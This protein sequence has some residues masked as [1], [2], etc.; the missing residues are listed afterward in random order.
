[1]ENQTNEFYAGLTIGPIMDV[2]RHS[3]KTKEQW[4]GSYFFSWYMEKVMHLLAK[5]LGKDI[6]LTPH[7]PDANDGQ[8]KSYG[9]KF[10]DRFVLKTNCPHD[11]LFNHIQT[12]CL[13]TQQF[14]ANMIHTIV[15]NK[16][17]SQKLMDE[18]QINETLKHYLQIRFFCL[19]SNAFYSHAHAENKDLPVAIAYNILDSLES[20]TIVK[21]GK[22]DHTCDVCK[23]LPACANHKD[24]H[25]SSPENLCPMCYIKR[26]AGNN[27]KLSDDEIRDQE[28]D[29][30]NRVP[31]ESGKPI[32]PSLSEISIHELSHTH[33]DVIKDC[34]NEDDDIDLEKLRVKLPKKF[35]KYH[36]YFAIVQA[37][38]DNLGKLA[39]DKDMNPQT[40]SK[41]LFDF[42]EQTEGIIN[43]YGG[44]PVFLGGDDI[45]AYMPV[46]YQ[47]M[48]VIDFI[49]DTSKK[50]AEIVDQGKN[51]TTISFG[52]NIV[53]HKFP[54]ARALEDAADL[55]FGQAKQCKEKNCVAVCLTNHSGSKT[56]FMLNFADNEKITQFSNLLKCVINDKNYL[57]KGIAYNLKRFS[58]IIAHI[59]STDQ[60]KAFFDNTLNEPV[61][62]KYKDSLS[63][64][65]SF[66]ETYLFSETNKNQAIENIINMLN[67]IKFIT[68]EADHE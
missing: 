67:F 36:K 21:P 24:K 63:V 34:K 40:L 30:K 50:Y 13:D 32:F 8:T 12:A 44:Y 41:H 16:K 65:L 42:A 2:M 43:S 10:P 5:E 11:E 23:T 39:E 20:S 28:D 49:L 1:M 18:S 59:T 31:Y 46:S 17:R 6:F 19:S 57:P 3:K 14:F 22:S 15:S 37:D 33:K 61:F 64:L 68:D 62:S 35:K 7:L 52:L 4:F 48:S 26:F 51:K 29:L 60:L 66:F 58:H 56:K 25:K 45:L 54:L 55:L 27:E 9:G 47:N 53:Y 38:G